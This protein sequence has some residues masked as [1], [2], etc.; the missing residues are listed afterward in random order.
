MIDYWREI[1]F[2]IGCC[3]FLHALRPYVRKFMAGETC[4]LDLKVL[5]N[6]IIFITGA[7]SGIGRVCAIELAKTGAILILACRDL[8]TGAK[9]AAEIEN[10]VSNLHNSF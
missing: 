1:V 2:C 7:N 5:Q 8:A 6:K 10:M 4:Q 3:M 9:V